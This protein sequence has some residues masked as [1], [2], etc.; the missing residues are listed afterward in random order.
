MREYINETAT[1][2][3]KGRPGVDMSNF[4]PNDYHVQWGQYLGGGLMNLNLQKDDGSPLN[5][6]LKA[7][8]FGTRIRD[9]ATSK[10]YHAN[11]QQVPQGMP[12]K[13]AYGWSY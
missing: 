7:D 11:G 13:N 6:T 2:Q 5:I 4:N 8:A 10:A 9:K 3:M 1:D 12:Q